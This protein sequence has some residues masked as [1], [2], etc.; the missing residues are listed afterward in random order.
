LNA[1]HVPAFILRLG[2][3]HDFAHVNANP[4]QRARPALFGQRAQVALNQ[5]RELDGIRRSR[6]RNEKGIAGRFDLFGFGELTYG[7]ADK[8]M[9]FAEK[10]CRRSVSK[11]L[12]QSCGTDDIREQESDQSRSVLTFERFDLTLLP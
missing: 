10:I 1:K 8:L 7:L 12:F 5:Q 2:P 6:K 11:L 9:V 3:K 4:V